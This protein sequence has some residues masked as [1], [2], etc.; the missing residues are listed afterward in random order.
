MK[1]HANGPTLPSLLLKRRD[2]GRVVFLCGAGVSSNSGLPNFVELTRCVIDD[3]ILDIPED[4]EIQT[5]FDPWRKESMHKESTHAQSSLD[6]IFTLLYRAYRRTEVDDLVARQL[7]VD[8]TSQEIGREHNLIKR[9]SSNRAGIPQVVTTNFDR[10][11]EGSDPNKT[12]RIHVPPRL[13]DL[14]LNEPIEGIT[15]L[16]GRLADTGPLQHSL[17]LSSADFG[18]AYLSEG[19]AAN[20]LKTLLDRYTV[21]LIGYQADDPPV[22]YLL[23]G[24][25]HGENTR[26]RPYVFAKGNLEDIEAKWHGRAIPIAYA[27]HEDLWKTIAVWAEYADNPVRWKTSVIQRAR[28]DPKTLSP[29]ERGQ[30]AHVLSTVHGAKRLAEAGADVHPEWICVLDAIIRSMGT[31][32]DP[33][34]TTYGVDVNFRQG[35]ESMNVLAV[36][37]EE[38]ISRESGALVGLYT[39]PGSLP[40]RLGCLI[41]WIRQSLDRPTVAWWAAR[42]SGLHPR[43]LHVIE[44]ALSESTLDARARTIW[45]LLLVY[46]RNDPRNV[47]HDKN[48]F[49]LKRRIAVEGWMPGVL[50]DFRRVFHPKITINTQGQPIR[51]NEVPARWEDFQPRDVFQVEFPK[52][53][54]K[55]FDVPDTALEPVF[56]ILE[57]K[58]FAAAELLS[59]MGTQFLRTPTCYPGRSVSGELH[60]LESAS[61]LPLFRALFDRIARQNPTL[62]KGHA[63]T[64]PATDQFYFRKL[65]LYALNVDGVFESGQVVEIVLSLDQEAFWDTAVKRELLFLLADRWAEFSPDDQIR[66]FER[67]LKGPDQRE[68]WPY[69][70]YPQWQNE[71]AA[72]Y[73]RY[74]E[75]RGC[76]LSSGYKKRLSDMMTA[77]P[78]WQDAWADSIVIESGVRSGW[79]RTD[80]TPDV[81]VD[82]PVHEII[83]TVRGLPD[84]DRDHFVRY[85]PFTGLIRHRPRKAL[86]A[87]TA[88]GRHGDYPAAFWSEMIREMPDNDPRLMRVV[89][90][91]LRRVPQDTLQEMRFDL[92]SW[93]N[94]NIE[95]ILRL[96]ADLAWSVYDHIVEN[97]LSG[98]ADA[99]RSGYGDPLLSDGQN[100]NARR[101]LDHALNG[102]IGQCTQALLKTIPD[103]PASKI[104][105][106]VKERFEQL[107]S[108]PGEGSAHAVAMTMKEFGRLIQVDPEWSRERLF[109]LLGAP[110]IRPWSRPGTAFF[111]IHHLVM[112][113]RCLSSS[114]YWICN[115]GLTHLHGR[116]NCQI[117]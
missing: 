92:G 52:R 60:H 114:R 27:C 41:S 117:A 66:L 116:T 77:I 9:I 94:K 69:T 112:I 21:V 35:A 3:P 74:L 53:S 78:E 32:G 44:W 64:W 24:L 61:I 80:D 2:E 47:S 102:P 100:P 63:L 87:L 79:V 113:W 81:L 55:D 93:L 73:G 46:H 110:I 25:Y 43:L 14:S 90:H 11:F 54:H 65:K 108:A 8:Q 62:A 101:T 68:G 75:N 103:Q 4:S 95:G 51:S 76:A 34:D 30:F 42:Q 22:R 38:H 115:D 16:H 96:D 23:E 86:A 72:C 98:G 15:Y 109:P 12:L 89:L 39:Q 31:Q 1:F 5:A 26:S 17:I 85:Q 6:H 29:H 13:P 97:I 48:I 20:F 91:W 88:V 18:R 7:T 104:P 10:L 111:I 71:T 84:R 33:Q 83:D 105:D 50:R 59:D 57:E 82:R 67:I 56:R 49:D 99:T 36:L 58:L 28:N 45:S 107:L 37:P 40:T 70:K 19:W 106:P